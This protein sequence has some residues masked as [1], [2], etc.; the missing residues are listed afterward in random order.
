LL[1]VFD[2]TAWDTVNAAVT[3]QT[4][5]LTAQNA[6]ADMGVAY[7][8]A[9]SPPITGNIVIGIWKGSAYMLTGT[10]NAA[11]GTGWTALGSS[12]NYASSAEIVTGTVANKTIAPDQLRASTLNAPTGVGGVSAAADANKLIRLNAQGEI[13]PGFLHV[14]LTHFR[15][16]VDL[17]TA[18]PVAPNAFNAGDYGLAG[19]DTL[20]AAQNAGWSLGRDVSAGDMIVYDGTNYSVIAATAGATNAVLRAG[21]NAVADDMTIVM[22]TPAAAGLVTRLDGGDRLKSRI[23]N[24]TIDAGTF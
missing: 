14:E 3:T 17:T 13:D 11:G 10:A 5:D 8:G 22:A 23:D 2:G 9:G 16:A 15:G 1:K 24:F 4:I 12:T 6:A 7:T 21:A 20:Q 18:P 19:A